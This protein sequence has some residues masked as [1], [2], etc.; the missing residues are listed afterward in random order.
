MT[1]GVTINYPVGSSS[2]NSTAVA[3]AAM[4]PTFRAPTP[5]PRPSLAPRGNSQALTTTSTVSTSVVDDADTTVVTLSAS[6]GSVNEGGTITYT[7]SVNNPVTG[8]DRSSRPT[9][10]VTIAHPGGIEQCQQH[11]SSHRS[12]EAHLQGTDT[13]TKAIT[14]TPAVAT[15]KR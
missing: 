9:G 4:R 3:S 11:G 5:L 14:G 6:A 15:S 10:G 1:G 2:A 7:A 13:I 12:D 8:S